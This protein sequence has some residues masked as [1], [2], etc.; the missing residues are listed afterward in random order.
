MNDDMHFDWNK[1]VEMNPRGYMEV[2]NIE[3]GLVFHGPVDK[4]EITDEDFVRILYK[5]VAQ[6]GTL[7][8]GKFGEWVKA[9]D[10]HKLLVFPNLMVPFRIENT[11][12]KGKRIRFLSLNII[13]ID[14]VHSTVTP[15]KVK[16]LDYKEYEM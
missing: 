5:W 7:E 1:V 4:I 8:S 3:K 14:D 2:Q 10:E 16:D 11:L 15:D 6:N 12:E 13:Y 9:P